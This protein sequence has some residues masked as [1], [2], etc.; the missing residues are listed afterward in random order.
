MSA[1]DYDVHRGRVGEHGPGRFAGIPKSILQG[2][3][4]APPGNLQIPLLCRRQ[5]I[6]PLNG[7]RLLHGRSSMSTLRTQ[8]GCCG[9]RLAVGPVLAQ[10]RN[11]RSMR[12]IEE[13]IVSSAAAGRSA[14]TPP[15]T[16]RIHDL[17]RLP[18]ILCDL[19]RPFV[20]LAPTF[21]RF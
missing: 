19:L 17:V 5:S 14:S 2:N 11:E 6:T 8:S 1:A 9:H 15:F 16:S 18:S 4:K 12:K 20:A 10:T 21:V 13:H 7:M 3:D